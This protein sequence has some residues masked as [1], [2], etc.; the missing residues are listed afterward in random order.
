M[1]WGKLIDHDR[2]IGCHACSVACK[3]EHRVPLGVFRTWVKQVEKGRGQATRRHFGVLRCN[4]CDRPPCVA[5][6]PTA[7]MHQ[8][9]DGIV[10]FDRALCVGCKACIQA[11]PYDAIY[12]DPETHTAAKCNFCAHRV[13]EGLVPACVAACPTDALL[14]SDLEDPESPVAR[15][16]AREGAVVRKPELG[17]Q[18]KVFYKGADA[19]V[20]DPHAARPLHPGMW[21]ASRAPEADATPAPR[22]GAPAA[23]RV[24]YDV[25]RERGPWGA[26]ISLYLFA[27]GIGA[28]ALMVGGLALLLRGPEALG[29]VPPLL[30]LLGLL[31]TLLLLVSDLERPDRFLLVLFRPQ[32]RSWLVR[33]AWVLSAA[34]ALAAAWLAAL[35]LGPV[36]PW[37][38]TALGVGGIVLGAAAAGY[39]ALLFGQARG[40]LLWQSPLLLP[41]LVVQAF[42]AGASSLAVVPGLVDAGVPSEAYW[43]G[44]LLSLGALMA[45]LLGLNVACILGELW[46]HGTEDARLAVRW[47]QRGPQGT[48]LTY[49]VFILGHIFPAV[50][51]AF[52]FI[53]P[54]GFAAGVGL[55]GVAA[56]CGLFLWD[57]L[58][59]RA[60]Q[61]P[62][63]S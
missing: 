12:I 29:Q 61:V 1:L 34:V 50:A 54:D 60:G 46:I 40:R 30:G 53:A 48:T 63:L 45:P 25:P 26:R 38:R 41:H 4:Q 2:C 47:M 15:A 27:K 22:R 55:A 62:P 52:A 8:R 42:L 35:S 16:V 10:D 39:T 9:T 36:A 20:L 23:A 21:G 14:V 32:P 51:L 24:A 49:G 43:T 33:G 56:L 18:P 59:L 13:E 3:S 5:I 57:D 31:A 11:C 6:C 44:R 17:T 19:S 58:Y 28:G 37:V 7:A